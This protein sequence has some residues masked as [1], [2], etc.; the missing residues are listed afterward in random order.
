MFRRTITLAALVLPLLSSLGQA[1][2]APVDLVLLV[3]LSRETTTN[4][5]FSQ[6]RDLLL[7]LLD[8]ATVPGAQI[9]IV[10][11]G[12]G[13]RDARVVSVPSDDFGAAKA[14]TELRGILS[15]LRAQ[16]SHRFLHA[17]LV[18]G[19]QLLRQFSKKH[20]ERT[21]RIVIV[22][23]GANNTPTAEAKVVLAPFDGTVW[24]GHFR[25][26]DPVFAEFIAQRGAGTVLSLDSVKH[27]RWTTLRVET[28][29]VAVGNLPEGEW[30]RR[31]RLFVSGTPGTEIAIRTDPGP[32][33]VGATLTALPLRVRLKRGRS[34]VAINLSGYR[35]AG[36]SYDFA[37]VRVDGVGP[38]P[39]WVIG[40]RVSVDAGAGAA[41]VS[42]AIDELVFERIDRGAPEAKT[43][44]FN[45]NAKAKRRQS[46]M[47]F[48]VRDVPPDVDIRIEPETIRFDETSEIRVII[49]PRPGAKPGQHRSVLVLEPFDGLS[50]AQRQIP[51]RFHVGRGSVRIEEPS[52]VIANAPR[53]ADSIGRITL[54][55]DLGA[56]EMGSQIEVTVE[57]LP[58]GVEVQVQDRFTIFDR[59]ALEFRAHVSSD[60]VE[61]T[62]RGTLRF[63]A[64]S[65]VRMVPSELPFELTVV[66]PPAVQLGEMITIGEMRQ[67]ELDSYE[68]SFPVDVDPAHH[69]A[70]VELVPQSV[71]TTIEPS[72]FRLK[73][74]RQWLAFKLKSDQRTLG[75]QSAVFHVHRR[76][77]ERT[78]KDGEIRLLWTVLETYLRVVEWHPPTPL[79][80]DSTVATGTVVF[81]AS[82]DLRGEIVEF[83]TRFPESKE[84]TLIAPVLDSVTL[85]GG[86]QAVTVPFDVVRAAPGAHRGIID[87][88]PKDFAYKTSSLRPLSMDIVVPE[89]TI[90]QSLLAPEKR[91]KLFAVAGGVVALLLIL[92]FVLRRGRHPV[93]GMVRF[94][95]PDEPG[96]RG[97]VV[98]DSE[99]FAFEDEMR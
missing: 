80:A 48:E 13:V 41:R 40:S 10:P 6:G 51:I 36:A 76:E 72:R 33:T 66:P 11:F 90:A 70:V 88:K 64:T 67:S 59:T 92:L 99:M 89:P 27:M 73:E 79:A 20:P 78:R 62:I 97:G 91:M 56:I 18:R 85:L 84:G 46:K 39:I 23:R 81:D 14:R 63:T 75:K 74:G 2:D 69:G 55:P 5:R 83:R 61:G 19:D 1:G 87:L 38:W 57:G 29:Y 26:A 21:R 44:R 43:I 16:D 4:Q 42:P 77:G 28:P 86:S 47:R 82:P 94:T 15:E 30:R 3:D 65:G 53:G 34:T 50:V 31:V 95:P 35:P 8:R 17:A 22:A 9:A 37:R 58:E 93:R 49:E 7:D 71:G 45:V 68:F 98:E 60:Q 24:Y 54:V 12:N 25:E 52:L 32:G 96:H